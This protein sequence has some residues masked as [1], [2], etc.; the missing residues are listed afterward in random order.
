MDYLDASV[1]DHRAATAT[2]ATQG[3]TTCL[4]HHHSSLIHYF[5]GAAGPDRYGH[6]LA[7]DA[8]VWRFHAEVSKKQDKI[9]VEGWNRGLET[10]TLFVR[11][12][13]ACRASG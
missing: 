9:L 2:T 3:T 4:P 6:E 7:D 8:Y 5:P 11:T 13:R 12:S 1:S 10:L